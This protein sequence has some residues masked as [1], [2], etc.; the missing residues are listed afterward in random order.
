M[1]KDPFVKEGAENSKKKGSH[2]ARGR[3]RRRVFEHIIEVMDR[4]LAEKNSMAS[5]KSKAT[6]N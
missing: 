1:A 6:L 4:S 2:Q 5:G 3:A